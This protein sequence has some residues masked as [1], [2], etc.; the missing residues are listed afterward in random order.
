M[1][2]PGGALGYG[3]GKLVTIGGVSYIEFIATG[4][5]ATA[6]LFASVFSGIL[7]RW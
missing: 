1:S 3:F 5:V 4:T 6:I 2:W 7:G